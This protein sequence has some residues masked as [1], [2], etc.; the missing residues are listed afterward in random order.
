M[1]MLKKIFLLTAIILLAIQ[2]TAMAY[3]EIEYSEFLR[4]AMAKAGNPLPKRVGRYNTEEE[5]KKAIERAVLA[6]GDPGLARHMS[7]VGYDEKD[8]SQAQ[9]G[10]RK[11]ASQDNNIRQKQLREKAE[12]QQMIRQQ[13]QLD[14]QKEQ[15]ART[16]FEQGKK[17][18]LERF[19][20][21]SGGGGL[22]LKGVGEALALKS[23]NI[24]AVGQGKAIKDLRNSVYWSL[25]AAKAAASGDNNKYEVARDLAGYP[26]DRGFPGGNIQLPSVPDVPAPVRA[27]PQVRLYQFLIKEVNQTTSEL[28]LVN[29]NLK[30]V[31]EEKKKAEQKI[32]L[33]KTKI[34][35]LK[36]KKSEQKKED[37]QE[38]MD[39]LIA[40]AQAALNEAEKQD[41][42][43][44]K[45]IVL[46]NE[47]KKEQEENLSNLQQ[48]FDTVEKHP[49]Q[50]GKILK[51]LEGGK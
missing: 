34:E 6:S 36:Q 19:K 35:E 29:T 24:S 18:M 49:E 20:G 1:S 26:F 43:A 31:K 27:D 42:D 21:G 8:S 41:R 13:K 28:K 10:R 38:D 50:A 3:W 22:N 17:E 47:Q 48:I 46:L 15:Q 44:S 5:C 9:Q 16:E 23:G 30:Q 45:K 39:G 25:E 11:G 33:Q 40:A 2:G 14:E 12:H 51:K 7:P 4:N 37:K 32:D